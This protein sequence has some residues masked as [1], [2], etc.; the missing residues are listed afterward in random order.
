MTLTLCIWWI[1]PDKPRP[2]ALHRSLLRKFT[3]RLGRFEH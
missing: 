2:Q 3:L 1:S